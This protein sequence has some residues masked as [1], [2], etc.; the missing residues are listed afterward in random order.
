MD[1]KLSGLEASAV[2]NALRLYMKELDKS[3]EEKGTLIEKK[4][5][6]ELLLRLEDMPSGEVPQS[7]WGQGSILRWLTLMG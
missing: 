1:L 4:A 3:G 5:V 7:A 2:M 6:K